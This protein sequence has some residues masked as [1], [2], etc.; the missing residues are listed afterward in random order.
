MRQAAACAAMVL[1][2]ASAAGCFSQPGDGRFGPAGSD[3]GEVAVGTQG[4]LSIRASP[5]RGPA[6]LDVT[7]TLAIQG[8][9]REWT[10]DFGDGTAAATG[11]ELPATLRHAYAK[12]GSA[13]AKFRPTGGDALAATV[14]ITVLAPVPAVTATSTD[15]PT[16]PEE[17]A[18]PPPPEYATPPPHSSSSSTGPT[19]SPEPPSNSSTE[20]SSATATETSPPPPA[21]S[22]TGTST[23]SETA[24]ASD[25]SSTTADTGSS[26]DTSTSASTSSQAA[27]PPPSGSSSDTG[28]ASPSPTPDPAS[29]SS[30]SDP[31]L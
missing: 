7:F 13:I 14:A 1:L 17:P 23:T 24:T 31:P 8:D 20:T 4:A 27:A 2:A 22:T 11:K 12:Q 30:S 16:T 26:S 25:T 10:L 18:G 9:D 19:S 28:T 5:A 6:P 21:N 3:V 15:A 29:S